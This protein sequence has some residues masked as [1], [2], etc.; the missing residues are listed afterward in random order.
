MGEVHA[1]RG[2]SLDILP[3][4]TLAIVGESGSGKSLTAMAIL[5]LLPKG[6]RRAARSMRFEGA[7]LT[8][9]GRRAL[10]DLRGRRIGMIFQDPLAAFDPTYT[11]GRQL[12]DVH[13]RHIGAGRRTA[14]ARAIDLLARVGIAAPE[15]RLDQYP[16]ELSGGIR[17]RVM[18]AM[19]LM[20]EPVLLLADEPTTALDVTIQAQVLRLLRTLQQEMGVAQLL[21]THD[22]GVVAAAADRVAV[23]YAGEIVEQGSVRR[24]FAQPRHPYTVGLLRCVPRLGAGAP[25]IGALE[26]RVPFLLQEPAGCAFA[27][28]CV[29]VLPACS[30]APIPL[31]PLAE[32]GACRCLNAAPC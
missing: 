19:A 6:A 7:E 9:L 4:E 12:E 13:L 32:G 3:G 21:I 28:R 5:G 24:V 14:R 22:L 30:L 29:R 10:E 2:V 31:Y 17:Q 16:H 23:M 25:P 26:G 11:I 18:I 8:T 20:C 15:A 27:D 1:V